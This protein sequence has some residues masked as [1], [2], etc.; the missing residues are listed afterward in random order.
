[1]VSTG[2]S[3]AT[4]SQA[5]LA[6]DPLPASKVQCVPLEIAEIDK[7]NISRR[8][9]MGWRFLTACAS[10]YTPEALTCKHP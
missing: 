6:L 9:C 10:L 3:R 5:A 8:M 7:H 1:M 2:L 4:R